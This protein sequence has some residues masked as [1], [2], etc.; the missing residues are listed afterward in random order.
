MDGSAATRKNRLFLTWIELAVRTLERERAAIDALNVFPVPDGDTGTN[1]FLTMSAAL[2]EVQRKGTGAKLEELVTAASQGALMGARGNSGVI[3]SQLMRGFARVLASPRHPGE[4]E[5]ALVARAL[6]EAAD[7]AYRAVIKP[8]EGT[9]LSVGRGAARSAEKAARRP[10]ARLADVLEAALEGARAAL[11]R[12]PR[13]LPVLAQAGVVD[14][15]GQGL[16]AILE[17][18][19]RA[20]RGEAEAVAQPAPPPAPVAAGTQA[21][22]RVSPTGQ[23]HE[24]M[25][26]HGAI[27]ETEV[28]FRYCTE[29]LVRGRDIPQETL[30][31]SLQ[32]LGDSLLVV[33]DP[34][35]VKVHLHTNHPGKALEIGLK[36]GELLAIS[37]NNMQEQNRQAAQKAASTAKAPAVQL[38]APG[39][40][41]AGSVAAHARVSVSAEPAP[42][43]ASANSHGGPGRASQVATA[44][45]TSLLAR[46]KPPAPTRQTGV[47]AVVSGDG[48]ARIFHSL[49]V[50]RI[51]D[52]GQTMNPSIEELMEA[53]RRA[54]AKGVILLPNNKN[55]LMTARQVAEI[56]EKPVR[57]VPSR[58]LPE[59][60]AAAL[61]FREDQSLEANAEQMEKACAR[62]AS[63]EVTYAIRD[64][65]FGDQAIRAGDIVGMAD[66]DLVSVGKDV[67][68]VTT[69]VARRLLTD[70]KS[71]LTL[72][73]GHGVKRDEA[74][75]LANE[76]RSSLKGVELEVY[77]GGQPLFF[78]LLA[79][80]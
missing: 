54:P 49:G 24:A 32:E 27:T 71:L 1:M 61:A 8:V 7:T 50:D 39:R 52:G 5:T 4:R 55:V 17:A 80:E 42:A 58:T 76:L 3:L 25:P 65:R 33:G 12:T 37:I 41:P 9:M 20:A 68:S 56:S 29:F 70:D 10:N 11:A 28:T 38:A 44:A 43:A 21:G 53:I 14:A 63:G 6:Q 40:T 78:Y 47:V 46:N 48:L 75:A 30:R 26:G 13:Q 23:A 67:T 31:A 51:V 74:E 72:Y 35:L 62:V 69:E 15:G 45:P 16:V 18:A 60:L 77:Y 66:G 59:G 79:A 36:W 19:V 57:V 73:Y 2:R 64:S 34:D 22:E